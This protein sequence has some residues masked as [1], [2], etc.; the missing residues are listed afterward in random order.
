MIVIELVAHG[1]SNRVGAFA[2]LLLTFSAP[3]PTALGQAGPIITPILDPCC[4]AVAAIRD[5]VLPVIGSE[6]A[7]LAPTVSD[8]GAYIRAI[9]DPI[10]A[11]VGDLAV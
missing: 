10:R 9:L 7:V 6:V 4:L 2:P 11:V 8:I 3:I 5:A 1:F